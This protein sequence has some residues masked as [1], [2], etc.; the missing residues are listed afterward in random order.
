M[1]LHSQQFTY[2]LC[3]MTNWKCTTAACSSVLRYLAE[4]EMKVI[5]LSLTFLPHRGSLS[6]LPQLCFQ[7]NIESKV[8]EFCSLSKC[9][10]LSC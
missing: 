6:E 9:S 3:I 5:T 8:L 1:L 2:V 10:L 7:T 4:I